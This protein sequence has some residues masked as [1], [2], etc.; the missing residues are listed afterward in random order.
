MTWSGNKGLPPN[1][2]Y[3]TFGKV[4]RF[5]G[6]LY[7][8]SRDS[9]TG[10]FGV[11]RTPPAAGNT[12]YSWSAALVTLAP[13]ASSLGT[14][15]NAD[16]SHLYLGE[17]GDPQE[18]R[19]ILRSADGPNWEVVFGPDS[20]VRHIHAVAPDPYHPGHVW[21][22]LGDGGGKAVM[23]ST[24]FGAPGSWHVVVSS[25][26]WQAVQI[27]FSPQWIFFAGDSGN[28]TVWVLDRQHL[29][30]IWAA[31]NY[32]ATMP[33]PG[34]SSG[35]AFYRNAFYGKRRRRDRRVLRIHHT[36]HVF[37]RQHEG[38]VRVA[39]GRREVAVRR[40]Q[41]LGDGGLHRRRP[42]L[43]GALQLPVAALAVSDSD[44]VALAV[45]DSD[46]VALAE[47]VALTYTGRRG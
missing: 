18:G 20:A 8:V 17:Y 12:P 33:V 25:S 40:L 9:S 29:Q 10:R 3:T 24:D 16:G 41:R 28:G 7:V 34:G 31:T 14:T 21:A 44:D 37:G 23:R 30:P 32:H 4:V 43:V 19:R 35:D 6:Y 39:G 22:T 13:G 45:S 38:A 42:R 47:P 1:T 5:K 2:S 36:R 11:Y 15:M 27:S 46:D 26:F